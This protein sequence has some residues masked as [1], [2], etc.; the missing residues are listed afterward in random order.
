[1]DKSKQANQP[2]NRPTE[3]PAKQPTR[4][5][6]IRQTRTEMIGQKGAASEKSQNIDDRRRPRSASTQSLCDKP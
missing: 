2:L 4:P 1:M 5:V 3:Q 6:N